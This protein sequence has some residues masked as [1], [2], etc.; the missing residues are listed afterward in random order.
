MTKILRAFL[1]A[2]A[3]AGSIV[4]ASSNADVCLAI[5][6]SAFT[7]TGTC[8]DCTGFGIGQLS[9]QNYIEGTVASNANFLSFTYHSNLIDYTVTQANLDSFSGTIGTGTLASTADVTIFAD[10][11]DTHSSRT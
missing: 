3:V 11:F 7:F 6:P 8:S 5:A 10:G 9:L 4:G 1:F 2:M